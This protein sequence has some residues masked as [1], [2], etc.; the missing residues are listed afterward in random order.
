MSANAKEQRRAVEFKKQQRLKE[1]TKDLTDQEKRIWKAIRNNLN[2][3]G[4]EY[5]KLLTEAGVHPRP[6][7]RKRGCKP[8]YLAAYKD[9]HENHYW[10][11][12]IQDEKNKM[13]RRLGQS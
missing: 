13:F 1:S 12:R 5:C 7:W 8:T 9:S 6:Q 10:R 11:H 3:E 2:A 4:E